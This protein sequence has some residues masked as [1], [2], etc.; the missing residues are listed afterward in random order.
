MEYK[1]SKINANNKANDAPFVYLI[2]CLIVWSS[3]EN[4]ITNLQNKYNRKSKNHI[5]L[6]CEFF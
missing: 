6:F 1:N 3:V 4:H 2:C 5:L